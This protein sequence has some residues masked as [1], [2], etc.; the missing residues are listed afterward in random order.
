MTRDQREKESI[1]IRLADGVDD[2]AVEAFLSEGGARPVLQDLRDQLT[3]GAMPDGRVQSTGDGL[4]WRVTVPA[5]A[6]HRGHAGNCVLVTISRHRD[7]HEGTHMH[8]AWNADTATYTLF[9]LEQS[10]PPVTWPAWTTPPVAWLRDVRYPLRVWL[11]RQPLIIR[12][13]LVLVAV[14]LVFAVLGDLRPAA[15]A[16][17]VSACI[18]GLVV[19]WRSR[20]VSRRRLGS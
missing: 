19:R 1:V 7:G 12:V 10:T 11:R 2:V 13:V 20:S 8:L 16:V 4:Y 5:H 6:S 14:E 3:R 18:V 9:G 17:V 15:V